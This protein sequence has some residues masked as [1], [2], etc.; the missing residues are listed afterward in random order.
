LART[1]RLRWTRA[2]VH[3]IRSRTC[4]KHA[5]SHIQWCSLEFGHFTKLTDGLCRS[6]EVYGI[7]L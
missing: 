4:C 3:F 6:H 7:L 5:P 2:S 1:L